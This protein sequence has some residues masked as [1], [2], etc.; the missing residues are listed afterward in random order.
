MFKNEEMFNAVMKEYLS[1]EHRSVEKL[2]Q[3]M[4]EFIEKEAADR[5]AEYSTA[6]LD[7]MD[8]IGKRH[9]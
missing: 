9:K 1:G 4:A 3:L 2:K 7:A 5:V 6:D 8:H